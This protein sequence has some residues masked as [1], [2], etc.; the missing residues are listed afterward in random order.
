MN[1]GCRIIWGH[2]MLK[3]VVQ[4]GLVSP[5][6]F[7]GINGRMAISCVL[8]KQTSY[9]IIC[10]IQ[11]MAIIFDNDAEVAYDHM[12]PS[13]CMILS[14][15]AGVSPSAIQIKL[16][17]LM[18]MK[19]FVKTAYGASQ[20]YFQNMFLWRI[21]GMLQGSSEDCLI[22][23]LSSSVQF[24]VIDEQIPMAVFPSPR[25]SLYTERNS[26]GF[27]DDVTLWETSLTPEL[28]EVQ[29]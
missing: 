14:A 12:I 7:G 21:Y 16:T 13:Q 26:E 22:W 8:L 29:E 27:V 25:P 15:R 17:V 4:K 6:Q 28:R 19:N 9:D 11:L 1:M 3:R 18:R 24:D 2:E 10:L 23:S 5:Y 20:D